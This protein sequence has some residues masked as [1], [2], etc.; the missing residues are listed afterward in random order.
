MSDEAK[1]LVKKLLSYDP[2][3]G[4]SALEAYNHPWNKKM[5]SGDR[6]NKDVAIRTL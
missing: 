1:D 3:K 6:I 2:N 4:M 5:A